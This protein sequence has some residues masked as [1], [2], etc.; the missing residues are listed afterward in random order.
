VL[1]PIDY[2]LLGMPGVAVSFWGWRRLALARRI[3]GPI[4]SGRGLSGAEVASAVLRETNVG[5]IA[6]ERAEG[7]LSDYYDD[8]RHVLRLSPGVHGGRSLAAMG[9]AAHEAGHVLQESAGY[10]GRFVRRLIVPTTGLASTACWLIVAAGLFVGSFRLFIW[11]LYLFSAAVA[12]QLGNL[13]V[14]R[15]ASERALDV[16]RLRGMVA[17]DEE[18]TVRRVLDAATWTH[19]AGTLTTVPSLVLGLLRRLV[20]PGMKSDTVH[21]HHRG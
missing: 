19:V 9:I 11:G 14:E 21:I 5:T 3:A 6:T 18:T 10:P 13:P 1:L 17:P 8:S 7:E 12:A 15:D 2:I 20:S 4:G 16:L